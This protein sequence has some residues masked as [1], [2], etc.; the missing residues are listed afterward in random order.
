MDENFSMID[1]TWQ[2]VSYL[3]WSDLMEIKLYLNKISNTEIVD[4][5]VPITNL[6][7]HDS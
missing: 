4:R 6:T 2:F 1:K 5:M 7:G 3:T